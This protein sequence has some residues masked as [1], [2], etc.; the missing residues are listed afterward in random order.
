[1]PRRP[2]SRDVALR[3]RL[4]VAFSSVI[5][6]VL[7]AVGVT[8]Y[9]Q[10]GHY[11][12]T[13]TDS[14]L[15]SRSVTLRL[16]DRR[17]MEPRRLIAL[18][19]ERF[20]Q[21]YGPAGTLAASSRA[22]AGRALLTPAEARAARTAA[23]R[24]NR[25]DPAV[26]DGLRI[27]AFALGDRRVALVAESRD[28]RDRELD[29]LALLLLLSLPAALGLAS[30][31]GY[32]VAKAALRPVERMRA[33][34]EE[35]TAADPSGR[36]PVPPT[37]DELARLAGTLNDLLGRQQAALAHERQV[38]SDASHEL[39]TPI[40]VLRTRIAVALRGPRQ[41]AA[42]LRAVLEE[43]G[44]DADRLGRLADD[45]LVLARADQGRLPLRR[46]P[47]DVQELVEAAAARHAG[48][49]AEMG[50]AGGAVVLADPD[51][52]HQAL[53]NL[54]V[55][56]ARYGAPPVT[57]RAEAGRA[58]EVELAVSDAG[59]G[60]PATLLPR[61]FDRFSHG[62]DAR[63]Q[64][65]SGLGLAIVRAIAEAHGGRAD[66][67]NTATGAVVSITLPRA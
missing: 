62:E 64:G 48:V 43:A 32:Q 46:E 50:I 19:G 37:G 11:V 41:D 39:R 2:R 23:L 12:D 44:A 58:G 16:L 67:R 33:R 51:R 40:S 17:Q 57:L 63:A 4:T 45:L 28:P 3:I 1:M 30:F 35:I 36:L 26:R 15:A 24:G 56:A 49:R 25:R 65:G 55:N 61:A 20:A 18:S 53:D 7:A 54:L 42:S 47:L 34:A 38:V 5:A 31:T 8:V 52:I 13:N 27:R 21:V 10:F 29:H 22:L 60:F 14:D 9:A 6:L 66:A 59:D